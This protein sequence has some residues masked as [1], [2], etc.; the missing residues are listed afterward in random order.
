MMIDRHYRLPILLSYSFFFLFSKHHY[1]FGMRAMKSVLVMAGELK[2]ASPDVKEE[3][4]LMRAM[5]DSN[6]PKFVKEDVSLF[7]GIVSD[8]FPGVERSEQDHG[9]LEEALLERIQA[10]GFQ[11]VPYFVKKIIQL[12]DT[13]VV[14]HGVMLVGPTGGGKT[15]ARNMLADTLTYLRSVK[16]SSNPTFQVVKQYSLNPK[17]INYGELYGTFNPI[18]HEWYDGLIPHFARKCVNDTSDD[19][20]VE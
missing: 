12:Y 16:K 8:L 7:E 10:K 15:A 3:I 2:R 9:E 13:C 20:K 1:D 18:S 14:R 4:T 11:A 17:S 5:R 19:D 6:I